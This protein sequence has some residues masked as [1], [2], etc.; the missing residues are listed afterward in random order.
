MQRV[1]YAGAEFLMSDAGAVALL[2]FAALIAG[3]SQ[4]QRIAVPV[5]G[6]DGEPALIQA[7]IGPASQLVMIPAPS[8]VP[9]PDA[10]AFIADLDS[11]SKQYRSATAVVGSDETPDWDDLD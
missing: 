3:A 10:G 2:D 4:S 8:S 1:Y 9:D 5:V 7:I 6:E 11:R